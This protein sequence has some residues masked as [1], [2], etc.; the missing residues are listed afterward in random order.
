MHAGT[1][2]S[3]LATGLAL[4]GLL[5]VGPAL[6][7]TRPMGHDHAGHGDPMM[8]V[9]SQ[10]NLSEAQKTQVH[11]VFEEEHPRL[12][13]LFEASMQAHHALEQAIHAPSFDEDAIRAAAARLGAAEGDLAV[14]KGRL[15]SKI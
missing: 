11:G 7:G 8:H 10:L 6:G 4:A 13:P 2:L 1:K 14:E 9:L 3:M 15:A 12:A 5:T